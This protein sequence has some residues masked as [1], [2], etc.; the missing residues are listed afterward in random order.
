MF[1]KASFP[2]TDVNMEVAA[3]TEDDSEP[4]KG[5][6]AVLEEKLDQLSLSQGQFTI[7]IDGHEL[8]CEETMLMEGCKY[9]E[10]FTHFEK[11]RR[12]HIK[13]GVNFKIFKA[14]VDFLS[15]KSLEIDLDNCQVINILENLKKRN[16]SMLFRMFCMHPSFYSAKQL[17]TLLWHS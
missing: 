6:G 12:I 5:H 15:T 9:F 3:V 17:K 11:S 10:A 13:G 2:F 8:V 16:T 14:I 1:G 7:V 4:A